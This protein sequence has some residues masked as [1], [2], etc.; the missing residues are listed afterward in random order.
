MKKTVKTAKH[1]R[2]RSIP[3][4]L[5]MILGIAAAA[6]WAF[7]EIVGETG[8]TNETPMAKAVDVKAE[9][10]TQLAIGMK[11]PNFELE[12]VRGGSVA[13][14]EF[15]KSPLLIS[16]VFVHDSYQSDMAQAT[17]AQMVFV[18]S[19]NEQYGSKGL[20]VVFIDGSHFVPGYE[21][22]SSQRI[23]FACDW[24]DDANAP[25]LVDTE[26][27]NVTGKY[28][29]IRL[30]TTFLLDSEGVVVQRWDNTANAAQLAL[31]VED[32]SMNEE[33]GNK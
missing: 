26:D 2:M 31:A 27:E 11:A 23:N 19:L 4:I 13:L 7:E 14:S 15:M 22:D 30:P 25:L 10:L 9:W 17:R 20:H 3:V 24:L 6:V 1:A 12:D 29:V 5:L 16:F 21:A 28:G 33:R 18:K 8:P 32:Q